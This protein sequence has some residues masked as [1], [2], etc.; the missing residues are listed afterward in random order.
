M[1]WDLFWERDRR[2]QVPPQVFGLIGDPLSAESNL[3]PSSLQR[4]FELPL[5]QPSTQ[6]ARRS[7][8][9]KWA[10]TSLTTASKIRS[11]AANSG[12]QYAVA[13][14]IQNIRPELLERRC[15]AS[16]YLAG[17]YSEDGVPL[18][19]P[20]ELADL[21]KQLCIFITEQREN[22]VSTGL[23]SQRFIHSAWLERRLARVYPTKLPQNRFPHGA[24]IEI[25]GQDSDYSWVRERIAPDGQHKYEMCSYEEADFVSGLSKEDA[26]RLV[27][28]RPKIIEIKIKTLQE[29][30]KGLRIGD[31]NSLWTKAFA[32]LRAVASDQSNIGLTGEEADFLL[33]MDAMY[34]RRLFEVYRREKGENHGIALD[35]EPEPG[36]LTDILAL[37]GHAAKELQIGTMAKTCAELQGLR[38]KN[39]EGMSVLNVAGTVPYLDLI[40]TE[41]QKQLEQALD[42]FEECDKQEPAFWEQFCERVMKEVQ[43]HFTETISVTVPRQVA[44][45]LRES[46]GSF[47]TFMSLYGDYWRSQLLPNDTLISQDSEPESDSQAV[48]LFKKIGKNTWNIRFDGGELFALNHSVGLARLHWLIGHPGRVF[49]GE[50]LSPVGNEAQVSDARSSRLGTDVEIDFGHEFFRAHGFEPSVDQETLNAVNRQLEEINARLDSPDL[51][52]ESREKFEQD[53]TQIQDYLS[54]E[55][56]N[57]G[58]ARTVANEATKANRRVKKSLQE[59]LAMIREHDDELGE[60]LDNSLHL[61]DFCYHPIEKTEW[62]TD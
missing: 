47:A 61:N 12:R 17:R 15:L 53:R 50:E 8:D 36:G 1:V 2:P 54:R 49:S 51:D 59:A 42:V 37:I 23:P 58:R 25:D 28:L 14:A 3:N 24:A 5:Q 26:I 21:L 33:R 56:N 41:E 29:V 32:T 60:H 43:Q 55:T 22:L 48:N 4:L 57:R 20:A 18:Y 40:G 27:E 35:E 34:H 31:V 30:E 52:I 11:A 38:N 39:A 10:L 62:E 19:S 6:F 7:G 44:S 45:K 9:D 16:C 46:D 13:S